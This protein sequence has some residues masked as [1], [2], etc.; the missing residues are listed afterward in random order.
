MYLE[1]QGIVNV[2]WDKL[3]GASQGVLS[4]VVNT[5]TTGGLG[6][7]PA[8]SSLLPTNLGI[9][10]SYNGLI[11]LKKYSNSLFVFLS[12]FSSVIAF[13]NLAVNLKCS[14]VFLY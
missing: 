13:G 7:S 12:L 4:T 5:V 14:G 1:Q 6:G 10:L 2:N 3:Q 11:A 9:V 8:P